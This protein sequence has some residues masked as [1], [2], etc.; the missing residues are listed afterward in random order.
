MNHTSTSNCSAKNLFMHK[1]I[2][3]FLFCF[4]LTQSFA[5]TQ[6]KVSVYLLTQYNK[7]LHDYTIN[8]NPWGIGLGL[9]AFLN[10]KTKFQ[11]TIEITGDLYW[12]SDKVLRLNPEGS[13]PQKGNDVQGNGKHLCRFGIPPCTKHIY[14][15]GCRPKLHPG[16]NII[17]HKTFIWFL[18]L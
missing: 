17:R 7:T 18:L 1:V 12:E 6:R 4:L 5:Q 2:S 9:Q 15:V 13:I 11:P 16:K 10:N 14:I 8:N 3:T